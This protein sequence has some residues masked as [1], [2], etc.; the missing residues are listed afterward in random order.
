MLVVPHYPSD[1]TLVHTH[2]FNLQHSIKKFPHV[3]RWTFNLMFNSETSTRGK[4]TFNQPKNDNILSSKIIFCSCRA[5]CCFVSPF[6]NLWK[7]F[8][9]AP[10]LCFT[11]KGSIFFSDFRAWWSCILSIN[12][13]DSLDKSSAALKLGLG[14]LYGSV[15]RP[16]KP[17]CRRLCNEEL[18][19]LWESVEPF[20]AVSCVPSVKYLQVSQMQI[21]EDVRRRR[22]STP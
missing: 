18:A 3:S 13:H 2:T 17:R 14:I 10:K 6:M 15:G 12:C 7:W 22:R 8:D 1:V 20:A 16:S 21:A 5:D 11:E 9:T 4:K 19:W